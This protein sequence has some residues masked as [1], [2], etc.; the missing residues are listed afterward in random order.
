M[1]RRN[2]L[3]RNFILVV[4]MIQMIAIDA[5]RSVII[6][7]EFHDVSGFSGFEVNV[8]GSSSARS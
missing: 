7:D 4:M 3:I 5:W 1:H 6:I 8:A 2:W